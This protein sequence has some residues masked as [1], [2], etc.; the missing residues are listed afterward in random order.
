MFKQEGVEHRI[1]DIAD[2]RIGEHSVLAGLFAFK[3]LEMLQKL[4]GC[5]MSDISEIL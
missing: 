5:G 4:A 2:R 1:Y 3:Y